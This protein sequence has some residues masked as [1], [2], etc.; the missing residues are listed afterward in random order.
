MGQGE[1]AASGTTVGAGWRG[2][3][4]QGK[5]GVGNGEWGQGGARLGAERGQVRV[6]VGK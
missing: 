5:K 3:G 4:G 2:A 6:S 1:G